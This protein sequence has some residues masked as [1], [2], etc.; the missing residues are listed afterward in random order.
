MTGEREEAGARARSRLGRAGAWLVQVRSD[1]LVRNSFFIMA[2]TAAMGAFGFLFWLVAARL[3]TSGQIG[4]ATTLISATILIS[5]LGQFGFDATFVRYLPTSG[6]RNAEINT[7]IT[8]VSGGSLLLAL[9]YIL[10]VPTFVPA[11][12]FV[13]SSPLYATGFIVF[14]ALGSINLVTDAVFI[15]YRAAKYNFIVDGL[16]QGVSKV[17][18]PVMLVGLGAFGI[19][20]ASTGAALVAVVASIVLLIRHFE[21]RPHLRVSRNVIRHVL[22][23]SALNY[24]ASLLNV[25][26]VLFIPAIVI[27][28]RGASE[29]G[30]YYVAFQMANLLFAG[31]FAISASLFSEGSYEDGDLRRLAWR[32]AKYLGLL[33]VPAVALLSLGGHWLLLAFGRE[34][35]QHAGPALAVFGF[36]VPAVSLNMWSHVMLRLSRQLAALVWS[37]VVLVLVVC[38]LALLWVHRGLTWVALAY[39]LGNLA[40]GVAALIPWLVRHRRSLGGAAPPSPPPLPEDG[41][42][43]VMIVSPGAPERASGADACDLA[44]ELARLERWRVVLAVP[45]GREVVP[46]GSD[47]GAP[48][49]DRVDLRVHR[50]PSF[51][52]GAAMALVPGLRRRAAWRRELRRIIE[53]EGPALVAVHAPSEG[54]GDLIPALVGRIPFVVSWHGRPADEGARPGE[55]RM[56]AR[57]AWIVCPSEEL[58]DTQLTGVRAKCTTVPPGERRAA[59]VGDIFEAVIAGRPG[60][61]RPRLA[62]VAPFFHPRLGGVEQY[63]Y[64]VA[65][66]LSG[67]GGYEV[68]VL[69]SNHA[70][71]RTVVEVVDGLT[72][73][74]F[75]RWFKVSNTPVNPLWPL[76]LRR[77]MAANR[78]DLVHAHAPVP[79]MAEAAAIACGRRPFVLTYHCSL[80]K[81]RRFVDVPLA[82]YEAKVLPRLLRRADEVVSV[83]PPVDRWLRPHT[84]GKAH[85]VPPGVDETIFVPAR[86]ARSPGLDAGVTAVPTVLYVGRIE[87]ASAE[88]GIRHLV[89]A[90]ALVHAEL[91]EAKLVLVG[92]GDAIEEHRRSA[93]A[94]G[95]ADAVV[96]RGTLSLAA[97]VKAYQAA[98]VVVL[99][100]TTDSE[101]FGMVL[102]EAMACAK[103]VIGSAVG[104]IPFVI[105]D[106]RDGYLVPPADAD[107][108]AG[109]CLEVLRAP[110]LAAALGERGHRKVTDRFTWH[111]QIDKYRAIFETLAGT[112]TP[113]DALEAAPVL[114]RARSEEVRMA[115]Q[116]DAPVSGRH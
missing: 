85:L 24:V 40:A 9:A 97:L 43:T 90:F 31:S 15:A 5:Y 73:F 25:M 42:F 66:G 49:E 68:V 22:S 75:P 46:D 4:V 1:H 61:G 56:L 89:E 63:A 74:R 110:D 95:I 35:S 6:D 70:G 98:S 27:N 92:G 54:L 111:T 104:G 102:I 67:P 72:V 20:T 52:D 64:R 28:A 109:A 84:E 106:G 103:P 53:A 18:L 33:A 51:P 94:L 59:S 26:P 47:A 34:Y 13:R 17:A 108:L 86:F 12:R 101:S 83:S 107:A 115:E 82:A 39:L 71:R 65:R 96:F 21:Y 79:F 60:D 38:G 112:W 114:G 32:A 57:A 23:F 10:V 55:R 77:A 91:P 80:P 30:Y 8:L 2:S 37:N 45:D 69:T 116:S 19:F 100:S 48:R 41:R 11:L 105:D 36:A 76:R 88:K 3:F 58:R 78:V 81:G 44:V 113:P 99:P 50:L 29:A 93:A 87:R 14:T 7:G 16:I 62:V